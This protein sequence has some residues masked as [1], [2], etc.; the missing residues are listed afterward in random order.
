[1]RQLFI[2]DLHLWEQQPRVEQLF[3]QFMQQQAINA[4]ALYVLGD[5]FEVWIGDDAADPLAKKV[6]TAF[7]QYSDDGG[8]LYFMHGNRDF[9]LGEVFWSATG[10][11]LLSDP[12]PLQIAGQSA[13]LM[14]GDSLCTE[15]KEYIAFRQKVRSVKWQSDLLSL[16]IDERREIAQD[17]RNQSIEKGK[18]LAD[19]IT[20]V[21]DAEVIK[22]MQQANASLLI[23]GHTH[24]QARHPLTINNQPAERIVLGDWGE[25]G[26]VLIIEN[27]HLEMLNFSLNN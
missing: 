9:L 23:H 11:T 12:Y 7:R 4:D 19:E 13:L 24:R 2:S 15:D 17:M 27:N 10:G 14:H 1:M 22:V 5:L 16:S 6:I 26:S 18:M 8:Q 3:H 20:D 25:T 21:T